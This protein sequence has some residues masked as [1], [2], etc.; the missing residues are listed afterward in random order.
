[1]FEGVSEMTLTT[2]QKEIINAKGNLIVRASA[3]TGKTH[4]MVHKIE[5][6]LAEN[7]THKVI[8]AITFTIKAAKE[9]KERL[10]VDI[11]QHFIGTNNS[12]VIEE[13]IKPFMKDI[14]G[15]EYDIDMGTDYS[16][17]INSFE[18]GIVK[19]KKDSILPSYED[20]RENFIFKL[21]YIILSQSKAC[22]LY[23]KAKYLKL[24]IDE[25]QDCD[26]DMHKFFMYISDK[27]LI[28]TFIIGDEKQSIYMWRGAYP[29]AF[30]SVWE[31]ENFTKIFMRDNF[32]SNQQIQNYTNLL[33][34]DTRDLYKE[35]VSLENIIWIESYENWTTS[36]LNYL[37]IEKEFAVL[38]YS[39][40]NAKMNS[41]SI[42][43]LG[44]DC[45]FIPN[46]P[47]SD[48]TT[49]TAWLYMSVAQYC[50]FDYFSVYDLISEIPVEADETKKNVNKLKSFLELI[51]Y[52]I[53]VEELDNFKEKVKLLA[54]YL[55]LTTKDEHL[56]FLYETI[57]NQE[58]HVAFDSDQFNHIA[59]T[60]H[61]SKGLEFEQVI[62][63]AEDYRLNDMASI[64]NHYVATTRAEKKLIII[65]AN[66]WNANQFERNLKNI[67]D[68]SQLFLENV[69]SFV[70]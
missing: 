46:L 69:V 54:E 5:L 53:Q 56:L 27:L 51:D 70:D 8:A 12:F 64:Y 4:T 22:Q 42:E 11:S 25:Y 6:E 23:L 68:E 24:Y 45:K 1:M 59:I 31:K 14:Y 36:L 52:E 34:E 2:I 43:E 15:S 7:R 16:V 3:G 17:H 44:I 47:I 40:N 13:I 65:K 58:Y 28:D 57:T 60:V 50:I 66:N 37:D 48:I 21:A 33:I 26:R 49:D 55:N 9:I 32:R 41:E 63:F 29:E 62:V 35:T 38:R 18:E 61:S 30:K 20:N 67:L 10:A 39:N 19:I